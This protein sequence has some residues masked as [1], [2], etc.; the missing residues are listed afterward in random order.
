MIN[1]NLFGQANDEIITGKV[2]FITSKNVYVKFDT[3]EKCNIG[4]TLKFLNQITPCLLVKNKSSNSL[5][6]TIIN[7]SI[8]KKGDQVYFKYSATNKKLNIV[9]NNEELSSKTKQDSVKV[10]SKKSY[11]TSQIKG[12][13]SVASYSALSNIRDD[14]NSIMST[15]ALDAYHINNSKFSFES[16]L[17]YRKNFIASDI[18]YTR[19]TS[20]FNVYDLSL[21][22][23]MNPTFS[24]SL[25]RKINPKMSSIGAID[26]LQA[27]K[28][29]GKNYIGAIAGFRPDFYD[30][31]FNADLFEYGA[32][33][34][35]LTDSKNFD[36]QTT[37]G[38]IEQ[39]NSGEIDRKYAYLQHSS[40]VMSKLNIFASAEVDLYNKVNDSINSDFRLTNLYVSARYRFN[41]KFDVMLSFD[42]RK[43][44]LYY[45]TFQTEIE[46]ILDDDIA[47]QGLRMRIN[48][49]PL[50][51]L[52]TG[53]SY[54]K[55]FQ[56]DNQN[57]SDN[58]YGYITLSKIPV[59]GGR[60]SLDYNMNT[61]N[62]LKSNIFSIRH[63]RSIIENKLNADFYYRFANYDYFNSFTPT[64]KQSYYGA[65]LSLYI[66]RTLMLSVFGEFSTSS[67][68]D[69]YRINTKLVKRFSNKNKK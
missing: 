60:L 37:L 3:T 48:I 30:Y 22:Y 14:R 62:Y 36:S 56:S 45:E 34:G 25:G 12:R 11:N 15:I 13:V 59:V 69:N 41:R 9:A 55:R 42:S 23:D 65:N 21:K 63:S 10:K 31:S 8:V 39:R 29:F 52:Q 33:I 47:R 53:F 54:S 43:R 28:Y 1:T 67:L 2:S 26:G 6:C 44:I 66:N 17:N 38:F 64:N 24:I 49:R 51:Y 50:K 27:E 35:R 19:E 4:D 20:F 46:K 68:E 18:D 16:Y 57:K 40:T 7:E 58:I 5:V 61:S 32:Y